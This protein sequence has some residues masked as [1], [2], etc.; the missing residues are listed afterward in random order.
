MS[1]SRQR[2]LKIATPGIAA[3]VL[4]SIV[5]VSYRQ[6]EQFRHANADAT[7]ARDVKTSSDRV[8]FDL[9][10]AETGQ[11]GYLLT[12]ENLYLAPYNKALR[13]LPGDLAALKTL[14]ETSPGGP[15]KFNELNLL[16]NKK[17]L[18]LSQSIEIRR[19]Q[20]PAPALAIVLSDR[21]KHT[22]DA[23]RG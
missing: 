19:T 13:A 10:D 16:V 12:G 3:L 1:S 20:G 18:E 4:I 15:Q 22:M 17:L 7:Q 11:R 14:L 9:I 23:I 21:G 2:W 8:L 5:G 6:W